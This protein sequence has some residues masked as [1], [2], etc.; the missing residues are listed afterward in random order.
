VVVGI[1][2][3]ELCIE[4]A[5]SLKD[6]RRVVRSLKDR[7][8]H[9]HNVSVAETDWLDEHRRAEIGVAMI[10]NDARFVESCLQKIVN[11]VDRG[12]GARLDDYSIE[13]I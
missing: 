3:L 1:L 6:K 7:L 5:M 10:A 4:G 9:R 13:M 2:R 8:M 12:R 11:E